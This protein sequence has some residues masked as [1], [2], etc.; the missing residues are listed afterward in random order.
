MLSFDQRKGLT[1]MSCTVE[2]SEVVTKS[3]CIDT[4]LALDN[5]LILCVVVQ[6]EGMPH[7]LLLLPSNLIDDFVFLDLHLVDFEL[8]IY[9]A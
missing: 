8:L 3:L 2:A 7:K 6:D 9:I 5:S 4:K 1:S